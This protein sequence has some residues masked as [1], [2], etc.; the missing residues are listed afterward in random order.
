LGDRLQI[1]ATRADDNLTG[2]KNKEEY[3][4]DSTDRGILKHLR[5]DGRESN[6]EIAR[7]LGV[8]ETTIR[9]RIANLLSEGLIEIVAVPT[10]KLAGYNVSAI[11]GLSVELSAMK[12]VGERVAALREVRYCGF[13][14]GRFDVIIEAFFSDN[15][16]LLRFTLDGLGAIPGIT[17]VETSLI[18]KI[19][20]FSYEWQSE[21]M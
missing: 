15:E 5:L 13:S 2:S 19:G 16:H 21:S 20:K 9:K 11:L 14:T 12:E 6:V 17:N 7:K 4:I 1:M 18:L 3:A 10:P 8:T